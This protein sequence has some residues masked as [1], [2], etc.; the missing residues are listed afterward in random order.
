MDTMTSQSLS[1]RIIAGAIVFLVAFVGISV[2]CILNI[3]HARWASEKRYL[4]WTTTALWVILFAS[5][6]LMYY[7]EAPWRYLVLGTYFVLLPVF[8]YRV[9]LRRQVIRE[10]EERKSQ[11][12]GARAPTS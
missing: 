11:H 8:I 5:L 10:Y 9:S 1:P 2:A 12:R 4:F 6:G 7:L 3:R